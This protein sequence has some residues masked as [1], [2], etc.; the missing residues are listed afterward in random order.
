MLLTLMAKILKY[1]LRT[2]IV[3]G[4]VALGVLAARHFMKAEPIAVVLAPVER[5]EVQATVS[6]TRAGTV[7]TKSKSSSSAPGCGNGVHR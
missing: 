6:N 2:V 1:G 3:A 5:G 4:I 7:K